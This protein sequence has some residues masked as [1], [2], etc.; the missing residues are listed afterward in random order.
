[1]CLKG[2]MIFLPESDRILYLCSPSVG[3]LEDLMERGKIEALCQYLIRNRTYGFIM[4][5]IL[6]QVWP[7]VA[8]FTNMD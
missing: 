1:M 6:V 5:P 8:P 3:N 7:P 4:E 2:Q